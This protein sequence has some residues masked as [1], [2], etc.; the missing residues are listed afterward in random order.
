MQ[1]RAKQRDLEREHEL[2]RY[3]DQTFEEPPMDDNSLV[4]FN[5][6]KQ[7]TMSPFIERRSTFDH[8]KRQGADDFD[9]MFVRASDNNVSRASASPP[10]FR[11]QQ[12]ESAYWTDMDGHN[13]R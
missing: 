12:L 13:Q 3:Q 5:Q 6:P 11:K 7:R 10:S 9:N 1:T 4:Q 8:V 2:T